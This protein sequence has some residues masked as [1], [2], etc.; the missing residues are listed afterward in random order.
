M[1]IERKRKKKKIRLTLMGFWM[2]GNEDKFGR[3]CFFTEGDV[4]KTLRFLAFRKVVYNHLNIK[5]NI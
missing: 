3:I 2:S 4:S 5:Q 1:N